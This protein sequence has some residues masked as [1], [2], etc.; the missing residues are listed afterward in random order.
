MNKK[1]NIGMW[2]QLDWAFGRMFTDIKKF[3][4]H[5]IQLLNWNQWHQEEHWLRYDLIYIPVWFAAELYRTGCPNIPI[6]KVI[7]SVHGVAELFNRYV[8]TNNVAQKKYFDSEVI[9]KKDVPKQI[10]DIFSKYSLISV[11]SQELFELLTQKYLMKNIVLTQHGVDPE[12]F[13]NVDIINDRLKVLY[14]LRR[15]SFMDHGYDKTRVRIVEAVDEK[16]KKINAEIDIVFP[17]KVI[18]FRQM[19][20]FYQ[21]G[22]ICLCVSHSE[23]GPMS[24]FEAGACGL[25]TITTSVGSMPQFIKHDKNGYLITSKKEDEITDEICEKLLFLDKNRDVLQ[26]MK[27]NMK[28]EIESWCWKN[29]IK[30]WDDFFDLA[31]EK[32]C[33]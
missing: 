1:L 7:F 14:H 24:P 11:V 30:Q 10:I 29:K 27:S 22:D 28:E 4:K 32:S 31:Y 15:G 17:E 16:I 9:D 26:K 21:Q 5:N 19:P 2:T 6:K 13:K 12:E 25:I 18:D 8:D 3:S 23:G 33:L 20:K